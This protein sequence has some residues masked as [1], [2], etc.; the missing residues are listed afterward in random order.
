MSFSDRRA[1]RNRS[2]HFVEVQKV[3]TSADRNLLTV[4]VFHTGFFDAARRTA[5]TVARRAG[6]F[7]A[8]DRRRQHALNS[9]AMS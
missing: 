9:F 8:L 2:A 5:M 6:E 1:R 4:S 3:M 7:V